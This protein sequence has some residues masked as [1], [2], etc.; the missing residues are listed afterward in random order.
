MTGQH[1]RKWVKLGITGA[2]LLALFFF[3]AT[4]FYAKAD[5]QTRYVS[6][7]ACEGYFLDAEGNQTKIMKI[8]VED[9]PNYLVEEPPEPLSDDEN[10]KFVGWYTSP[11]YEEDTYASMDDVMGLGADS[12]TAYYYAKWG[13]LDDKKGDP[14]IVTVTYDYNGG[15]DWAD[16]KSVVVE[17]VVKGEDTYVSTEYGSSPKNQQLLVGWY[18]NKELS[19]IALKGYT[20]FE[21][22]TVLYAKWVDAWSVTV[23]M[24]EGASYNSGYSKLVEKGKSIQVSIPSFNKNPLDNGKYFAGIYT[25]PNG[26]GTLMEAYQSLE[27]TTFQNDELWETAWFE[28]TPV[29]NTKF[30]AYW[31]KP[32][33]IKFDANGGELVNKNNKSIKALPGYSTETEDIRATSDKGVFLGWSKDKSAT[34]PD[35][36]TN[37]RESLTLYAVWGDGYTVTFDANGGTFFDGEKT[38]TCTFPKGVAVGWDSPF[39]EKYPKAGYVFKGWF[40]DKE[41]T[42]EIDGIVR[43]APNQDV[44][45]YAGWSK[46]VKLIFDANGGSFDYDDTETST[47]EKYIVRGDTVYLFYPDT[48]PAGK[49][50]EG[51]YT[52]KQ[53]KNKVDENTAFAE[54][55]T[56]Y[57]HWIDPVMVTF[58]ANGG[59]L[60]E[61]QKIKQLQ[62]VP[63]DT[64]NFYDYYWF[65]PRY[66]GKYFCGWYYDKDGTKPF[67]A[68]LAGVTAENDFTV[69]AKWKDGESEITINYC[70]DGVRI[71]QNSFFRENDGSI[72]D[73]AVN[74]QIDDY[75]LED[76]GLDYREKGIDT[77][78]Y[79]D[80]EKTTPLKKDSEVESP[81]T[82]YGT[83][84]DRYQVTFHSDNGA[85][86]VYGSRMDEIS[87][88]AYVNAGSSFKELVEDVEIV[89][90]KEG[91]VFNGWSYD[92]DG[93]SPVK[94]ETVTKDT[95]LYEIT[96]P[97]YR[98]AF[99]ANGGYW[100][101]GKWWGFETYIDVEKGQSL[102]KG[103]VETGFLSAEKL[104]QGY[105]L[106]YEG[107]KLF[108]G[109]YEDE[110]LTKIIND[111]ASYVPTT[112]TTLY[113]KWERYGEK[114]SPVT[115]DDSKQEDPVVLNGV[116]KGTD[117]KWAL[118]KD[119]KVNTAYTGIAKN[120]YGWWR[121]VEGYVDFDATGIYK[122]EFGWWR[123]ENGKVDFEAD[124]IYRN[125]YGWW[126]T[127][128]GK[129][130][131]HETGIYK[132]EYGWW[133]VVDSIVDFTAN[134]IYN[135]EYGWWKTTNG[136]VT[137][138]E[139]G[140]FKNEYGW[141]KVDDSKVDF[142][143][144]G[145][146]KNKYGTWYVK[147]GKV[148]F[149]KNGKVTFEGKTYTVKN[150]KV[151]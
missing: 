88:V 38:T 71:E 130:T 56:L 48:F 76:V 112:N 107:D 4:I 127:T 44:T 55:T 139:D 21:Q 40:L 73:D 124:G 115:P 5:E 114:S 143:F 96:L 81:V 36:T 20:Q 63:G 24:G 83:V 31:A 79:L 27:P 149:N 33:E 52:D 15:T 22:D 99:D 64:V 65:D 25:E 140:V 49:V 11:N 18:D 75:T 109:C 1:E 6:F 151:Q 41:C 97:A 135:N 10:V 77:Q 35:D 68:D 28:Y 12:E 106:G 34:K 17:D 70:V 32:I 84:V 30:Y 120:Q 113:A 80:K 62:F 89:Q 111:V 141:W 144:T 102:S 19:G 105:G 92:R 66:E 82:V 86:Y 137:F 13:A 104:Q 78:W 125:E 117:G 110:A 90:H 126:K 145:I 14:R 72:P 85:V 98:V 26:A 47:Y 69:Y 53:Y 147:N 136:K 134:G 103:K 23:D 45:V 95:N 123:V 43:Y 16:G 39:F 7:D 132:N 67:N 94:N 60:A 57:A 131:F 9:G 133:R 116:V 2:L 50:F 138:V 46:G 51:W 74:C 59:V 101:L 118:Y 42:K 87:N 100:D 121:I 93:K 29:K 150:G 122:N 148:D 119:G 3:A 37:I 61:K 54:D 129:V 91:S 8:A 146:A 128:D 142:K 58:D 108:K